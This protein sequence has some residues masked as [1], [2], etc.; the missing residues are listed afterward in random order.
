MDRLE[1]L[2]ACR[3][4]HFKLIPFCYIN[5]KIKVVRNS[6]DILRNL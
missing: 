1:F 6:K 5:A 3:T 4:A 2:N